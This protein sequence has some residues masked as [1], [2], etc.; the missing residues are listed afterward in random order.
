[1]TIEP[2]DHCVL[3]Q[4]KMPIRSKIVCRAANCG[5]LIDSPGF[6]QRHEK[7][8]QAKDRDERGNASER[9][10]TSVWAKAR[11]TFLKRNPL[12][13]EHMKRGEVAQASV[14]DHIKPHKLGQAKQSGDASLIAKASE[15]FWDRSNWQALCKRCHD[16]KTATEDGGFGNRR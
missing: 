1:M 4:Q 12:C 11:L 3:R 15:L 2:Q 9:G 6:C 5:R 16:I 7:L 13:A 10:Y 8:N 14:V